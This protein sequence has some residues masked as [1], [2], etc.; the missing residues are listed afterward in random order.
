MKGGGLRTG[1][2]DLL[3]SRKSVRAGRCRGR[4]RRS[5]GERE[6]NGCLFFFT[7]VSTPRTEPAWRRCSMNT[8]GHQD[9]G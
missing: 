6:E 7:L 9:N 1:L 3:T 8:N 4:I 5:S 2:W